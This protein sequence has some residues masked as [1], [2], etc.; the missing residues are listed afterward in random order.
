MDLFL[1]ILALLC[2]AIA[3]LYR[4]QAPPSPKL[5]NGR[6]L[7]V[8][9]AVLFWGA[10]LILESSLKKG[11]AILWQMAIERESK[12]LGLVS[13]SAIQKDLG[14]SG[15]VLV[16]VPKHEPDNER[17]LSSLQQGMSSLLGEKVKFISP[18]SARVQASGKGATWSDFKACAA[19]AS[20][21]DAI[22]FF[23]S[24]PFSDTLEADHDQITELKQALGKNC[25][26]IFTRP[27]AIPMGGPIEDGSI[28]LLILPN[29]QKK[30]SLAK[31]FQEA[32][33][34]QDDFIV[35]SAANI[36][37]IQAQNPQLS[38]L[39]KRP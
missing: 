24:P 7:L 23:I 5:R 6:I 3:V 30:K 12:T 18:E 17:Y 35:I 14:V 33:V 19:K 34:E 37:Q 28:S 2:A 13:A 9:L 21:Y 10:S 31:N 1:Q 39:D 29:S 38:L 4:R 25:H 32:S 16:I 11:E 15:K 36:D 27:Y 26:L 22:V 20:G 8:V